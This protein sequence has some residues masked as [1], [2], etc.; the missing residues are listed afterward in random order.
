MRKTFFKKSILTSALCS[1]ISALPLSAAT[2]VSQLPGVVDSIVPPA[3]PATPEM[4]LSTAESKV[5]PLVETINQLPQEQLTEKS[6]PVRTAVDQL[7]A[8]DGPSYIAL[9]GLL[10]RAEIRKMLN[11][12]AKGLL[13]DLIAPRWDAFTLTGNLSLAALS[14]TN[15]DISTKARQQLPNFIQPAHVPVLINLLKVPGPNVLAF[16]ILQ[17]LSGEKLDPNPNLWMSWWNKNRGTWDWVGRQ[18]DRSRVQLAQT[19]VQAFDQNQFWYT[20]AKKDAIARWQEWAD[21]ETQRYISQWNVAKPLMDRIVHQPDKRVTAYLESLVVDPG[22]GDY[23]SVVLAWR[24]DTASLHVIQDAYKQWPSVGRALARGTLGDQT[25]LKDL[26]AVIK[27]HKAPLS[28]GIMDDTARTAA[29]KLP[30]YGLL[31]A[32]QAF[33]LLAHQRFGLSSANSPREKKKAYKKAERWLIENE[34]KLILDKKH[35]YYVTPQK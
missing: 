9:R 23:A 35:G 20:P 16:D 31:P 13:A 33:E 34:N 5:L 4:K 7:R 3:K 15:S 25:A 6:G 18:L 1:L 17:E 8:E 14:S 12:G 24:G 28:Y 21:S 29:A 22:F 2:P 10:A 19:P 26:L 30:M 32:E 11:P 27:T